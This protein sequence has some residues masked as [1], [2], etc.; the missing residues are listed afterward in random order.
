[1]ALFLRERGHDAEHVQDVVGKGTID[2]D[3]AKYARETD[4]CILTYDDY[5]L[6]PEKRSGVPVFFVSEKRT[7]PK[8]VVN[9]I[10]QLAQWGTT[11]ADLAEVTRI[12]PDWF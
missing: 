10:D 3:V 6:I 2:V 4:S 8:D 5:F 9:A 7:P 12:P 11:Q 1:M